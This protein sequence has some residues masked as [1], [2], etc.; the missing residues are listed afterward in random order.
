MASKTDTF[1]LLV[2]ATPPPPPPPDLVITSDRTLPAAKQGV[3]YS[4]QFEATGGVPPYKWSSGDLAAASA[5]GLTI[6]E[7]GLLSG[8]PTITGTIV[9]Q[10]TVTDSQ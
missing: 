4:F 8:T 3:P 1:A 2:E 5:N 9:F 10:A 7:S 6:S